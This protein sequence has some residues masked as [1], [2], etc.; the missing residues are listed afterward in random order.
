MCVVL[1]SYWTNVQTLKVL[2]GKY[3]NTLTDEVITWDID[4]ILRIFSELEIVD[5]F[6]LVFRITVLQCCLA[7]VFDI[8]QTAVENHS[9]HRVSNKYYF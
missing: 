3:E 7:V 8:L 4:G 6:F 2:S 1:L 5:F 9:I